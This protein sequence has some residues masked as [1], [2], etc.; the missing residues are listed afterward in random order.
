VKE[1]HI[2]AVLIL[3]SEYGIQSPIRNLYWQLPRKQSNYLP[4]NSTINV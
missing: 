2:N 3:S 4:I 1:F